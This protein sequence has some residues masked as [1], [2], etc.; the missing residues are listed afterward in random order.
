MDTKIA[1]GI[2]PGSHIGNL[3]RLLFFVLTHAA[4][5]APD[6]YARCLT[7]NG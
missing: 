6:G 3:P 4:T 7:H 1:A 2:H 5:I